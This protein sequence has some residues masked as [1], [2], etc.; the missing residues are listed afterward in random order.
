VVRNKFEISPAVY[1]YK[2]SRFL[3]IRQ[4]FAVSIGIVRIGPVPMTITIPEPFILGDI[5]KS[6]PIG[7]IFHQ[8]HRDFTEFI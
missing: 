7:I 5:L 6:V 2:L 1:F 4:S 8:M 3:T